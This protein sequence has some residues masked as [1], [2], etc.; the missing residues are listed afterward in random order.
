[1]Y[2]LYFKNEVLFSFN[3]L[4][5]N[6]LSLLLKA[7]VLYGIRSQRLSFISEERVGETFY[8]KFYDYRWSGFLDMAI[9]FLCFCFVVVVVCSQCL[10]MAAATL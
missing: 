3:I 1:M 7:I 5:P 4:L 2:V 6:L 10:S 8:N 9:C